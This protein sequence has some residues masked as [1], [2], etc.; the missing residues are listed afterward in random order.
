MKE[1]RVE[2]VEAGQTL[3]GYQRYHL[4]P[5]APSCPMEAYSLEGGLAWEELWVCYTLGNAAPPDLCTLT[6]SGVSP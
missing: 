1:V 6:G 2:A 5:P 3:G 4:A